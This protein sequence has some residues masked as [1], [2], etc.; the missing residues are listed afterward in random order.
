M[1]LS[2]AWGHEQ[3]GEML[4]AIMLR[5]ATSH[6]V[7]AASDPAMALRLRRGEPAPY[8]PGSIIGSGLAAGGAR[9]MSAR[10]FSQRR[11]PSLSINAL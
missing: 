5:G 4:F 6:P 7:T 10:K 3:D 1:V 9:E 2:G 11:M 8:A